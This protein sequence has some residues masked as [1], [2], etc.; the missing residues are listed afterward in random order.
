LESCTASLSGILLPTSHTTEYRY[1]RI[2]KLLKSSLL[3]IEWWDV[4]DEVEAC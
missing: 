3:P 4:D 2:L 1:I